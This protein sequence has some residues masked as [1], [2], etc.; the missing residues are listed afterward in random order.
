MNLAQAFDRMLTATP[1]L[2][3]RVR[4]VMIGEGPERNAV[5]DFLAK[6]GRDRHA[7]LPGASNDVPELLR[8]LDVFVLP[9]RGEGISNT[10]LEA[11]A[12]GLPVIATRVGG[13]EELVVHGQTG[14]LVPHSD[15]SALAAVVA[16]YARSPELRKEH[17]SA[18]RSRAS[19]VFSLQAMTDNYLALYENAL[20]S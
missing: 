11:M 3:D 6:S 13:N 7:W 20:R 2:E 4:L 15:P 9:S 18:G 19:D 14:A 16:N 5:E 17:G 10:I 1:E 12:S 8:Q